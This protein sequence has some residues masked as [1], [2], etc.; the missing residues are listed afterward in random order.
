M[1]IGSAVLLVPGVIEFFIPA[2]K[3]YIEPVINSATFVKWVQ[4]AG[5][6]ILLFLATFLASNEER[7]AREKAEKATP[8]G[9]KEQV[10][11]LTDRLDQISKR[12]WLPLSKATR[13]ALLK[14]LSDTPKVIEERDW[15][16][17]EIAR[18][19][20]PDCD[21]LARDFA[22][23][24]AKAGFSMMHEPGKLWGKISDG[25]WVCA[26]KD[27]PRASLLMNILDEALPKHCKPIQFKELTT[28]TFLDG[29]MYVRIAI[30]RKPRTD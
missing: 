20:F 6:Y 28:G 1:L 16:H 26:P 5:G 17:I 30:G 19:E 12:S 13:E 14:A 22:E 29:A 10:G 2:T 23:A 25:L 8:E 24:F 9:L 11:E 7:E 3:P 27:D 4:S 21:D 15:R 18:E